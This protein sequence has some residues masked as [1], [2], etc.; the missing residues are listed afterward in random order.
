[1]QV[2][3]ELY[4]ITDRRLAGGRSSAEV[5]EKAILGGVTL[6]QLREKEAGGREMVEEAQALLQVTRRYGIPLIIN[7]R[8]DVALAVGAEGVHLGQEDIPCRLA[9]QILGPEKIIGVSASTVEEAVQAERDGADYL[10]VG[11]VFP[12]GTKADAGEAIGLDAL[13]AIKAR[14]K[15]PVVAIGGINAANAAQVAATGVD[16]LAVVSAIV[17]AADPEEAARRLLAAFR[18]GRGRSYAGTGGVQA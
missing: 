11:A 16:G 8:L 7:D 9:R 4:A 5:M 14:V 12:T 18:S 1:M 15:I 10:G 13:A 3:Y 17:A 6:V 2:N